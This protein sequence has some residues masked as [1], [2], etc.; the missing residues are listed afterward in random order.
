MAGRIRTIKPDLLDQERFAQ[1]TD[2]AVRLFTGCLALVDDAGVCPAGPT[3]LGGRIFYARPR[4]TISIGKLL[5]ELERA[6]LVDLFVVDRAHYLVIV[7][8]AEKGAP[9]YQRIDKP[10]ASKFPLPTSVRSWNGIDAGS[11]QIRSDP[12]GSEH[13]RAI[14]GVPGEHSPPA[15][16]PTTIPVA[17]RFEPAASP[18]PAARAPAAPPAPQAR[19]LPAPAPARASSPATYDPADAFAR[20]RLAASTYRRVSDER[21][22]IARELK[23]PA[24]LPFPMITP[25]SHPASFRDLA[26]R[27]REEGELAPAV[28]DRIVDNLVAQARETRE[29]EWLAEKAFTPGGWRTAR[30]WLSKRAKARPAPG[31]AAGGVPIAQTVDAPMTD[32]ERAELTEMADRLAMNPAAAAAA[33]L[34]SG[35][36]P[37]HMATAKL[38]QMFGGGGGGGERAPPAAAHVDDEATDTDD[39]EEESA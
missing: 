20:G 22:A 23:L 11:D 35:R 6:R 34:A 9:T 26:D 1:L 28:C 30:A 29:I 17:P 37:A 31:P 38:V 13:A 27:V 19:A 24:P 4:S 7:G 39:S 16:P 12:K 3:Y 33:E 5:A 14:P 2:A 32:E 15:P 10:Q 21:I 36:V 18:P 8:W 25:S